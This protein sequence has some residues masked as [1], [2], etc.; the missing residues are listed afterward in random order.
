MVGI[1]GMAAFHPNLPSASDPLRTLTLIVLART[2]Q[3]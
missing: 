3:L 2:M 1:A